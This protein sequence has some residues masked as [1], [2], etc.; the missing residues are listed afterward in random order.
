MRILWINPVGTAGFDTYIGQILKKSSRPDTEVD[1]VSL[2]EG[3]PMH[4]EYHAYEGL[5]IADIVNIVYTHAKEFDAV[6]IGCFYDLGLR[7]AREVSGKAPVV[8]PC[9]ASLVFAS[10]LGNRFSILVGREK[11]IPKMEENVR[12][13]GYGDRLASMRSLGLGVYDFQADKNRTARVLLEQGKR[14]VEE[15]N[16]EVLILGCTIE[17]GFHEKMQDALGVP[18]IDAVLAPFK[19]A[20]MLADTAGRFS[21]YPSRKW[22][23]EEPPLDEIKEWGL[24]KNMQSVGNLLKHDGIP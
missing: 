24:F 10:H 20:E 2:P 22:G 6:V 13:Y 21:W 11:W 23:S 4:L 8:A 1:V 15:D 17:F 9:Q 5:V 12:L 14:A 7:E 19:L 16:A 3:R 18:V